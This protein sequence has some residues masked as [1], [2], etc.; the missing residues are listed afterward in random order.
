MEY[1]RQRPPI[2]KPN[3]NILLQTEDRQHTGMP[4][5]AHADGNLDVAKRSNGRLDFMMETK[6][7]IPNLHL[8]NINK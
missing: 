3:I 2:D 5:T 1:D 4:E 6:L 8:K 7:L